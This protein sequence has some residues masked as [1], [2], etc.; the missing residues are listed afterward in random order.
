MSTTTTTTSTTTTT[1]RTTTTSTSTS[2]TTTTP[3]TTTTTTTT[4]TTSTI[5]TS[6]STTTTTSTV[7]TTTTTT[8]TTTTTIDC[9]TLC[10]NGQIDPECNEACDGSSVGGAFCPGAL[11]D[12]TATLDT[13]QETPTPFLYTA[14][15]D[16]AQEVPTP[17]VGTPPPTGTASFALNADHTLRY[18]VS[19]QNL[20]GRPIAAHIH[21]A[22]AGT[23]G[24]VIVPL[25]ASAVT[26][27][28]G[29]FSGTSTVALTDAQ[30]T[31][32]QAGG[33]YVNVHT[34]ANS[35]GEIRGQIAALTPATGSAQFRVNADKTLT[36]TVRVQDLS[37]PPRAAHVHQGD[38]GVP[39]PVVIPLDPSAVTGTS[40]TFSGTSA[41]LSDALVS[42]FK[43]G[44][45]YVNVHTALN[46]SGEIRGQIAVVNPVTC[47]PDC[48]LNFE[49]CT[50]TSTTTTTTTTTSTTTTTPA[51]T[52]TIT[53]TTTTSTSITTTTST[54]TTSITTTTS[55]PQAVSF[56]QNVAPILAANCT[57]LGCHAPPFLAQGMDLSS[58][59]SAYAVLTTKLGT[60]VP[61]IGT[62]LVVPGSPDASVLV[63]KL[64]STTCGFSQM[65][66]GGQPLSATDITTIRDWIAEGAP[67]N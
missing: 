55:L 22:P 36:Y 32:L 39:G 40:G 44:G 6:T 13:A 57:F 53:S 67:N 24:P 14:S 42:A 25:D 27:T 21:Q 31:A 65:P 17:T 33:L 35:A 4:S 58:A 29:T 1:T 52:S 20:S 51:M 8:S 37:G 18:S 12:G 23:P 34:T 49:G 50:T 59:A 62:P 43:A 30:V 2:T 64:T 28:S 10:G 26:G 54:T 9:R 38:A 5:T 46:G 7:I 16:A 56:T 61:C 3:A 11:A 15:L 60:E 45:L 48:T 19:V 63:M 41:P 47:N 66:L